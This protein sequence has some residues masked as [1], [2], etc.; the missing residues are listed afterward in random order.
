MRRGLLSWSQDEVPAGVLEDLTA[1]LGAAAKAQ[2]LDAVLL[3]G[4]SGRPAALS[5]VTQLVANWSSYFLLVTKD[6]KAELIIGS[7]GQR[8][9]P[10][11]QQNARTDGIYPA[12]DFG[13]GIAERARELAGAAP[14]IG[15]IDLPVFPAGPLDSLR[16]ACPGVELVDASALFDRVRPVDDA[17]LVLLGT[18]AAEIAE[19]GIAAGLRWLR[20]QTVRRASPVPRRC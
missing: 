11:I 5:R 7:G 19:A 15:V 20:R 10:W 14:R 2:G 13:A 17:S 9:I 18:R 16:A 12:A 3:F 8:G 4:D 1:E 6:G